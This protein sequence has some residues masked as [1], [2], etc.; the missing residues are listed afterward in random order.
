MLCCA[1]SEDVPK[2]KTPYNVHPVLECP[3]LECP[4]LVC[5]CVWRLFFLVSALNVSTS[6][7][8]I[9]TGLH[10]GVVGHGSD[11]LLGA[12][13]ESLGM[14]LG[15][16]DLLGRRRL[17]LLSGAGCSQVGVSRVLLDAEKRTK[18]RGRERKKGR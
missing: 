5:V 10:R 15:I 2:R 14:G 1:K 7:V 13:C 3:F 12:V 6:N 4:F 16:R 18:V 11:G 9:S 17:S 8:G